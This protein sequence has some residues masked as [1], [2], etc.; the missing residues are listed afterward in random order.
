MMSIWT[1]HLSD[2][3][4]IDK[5]QQ[6]LLHARWIF[7]RQREIL[8]QIEKSIENQ[9]TKSSVYDTPNWDYKQADANGSKRMIRKLKQLINLDHKEQHDR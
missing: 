3:E 6:G 9:E 7:D 5:F 2:P 1:Q 4:E 8:D